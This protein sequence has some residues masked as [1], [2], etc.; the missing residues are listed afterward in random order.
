MTMIFCIYENTMDLGNVSMH[1][2]RPGQIPRM[3]QQRASDALVALLGSFIG[4]QYV[5]WLICHQTAHFL[6]LLLRRL[7]LL[8]DCLPRLPQIRWSF[9]SQLSP[10]TVDVS[11]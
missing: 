5:M 8:L 2:W 3:D 10:Q 9:Q 4:S 11:L 7:S 6:L 1:T